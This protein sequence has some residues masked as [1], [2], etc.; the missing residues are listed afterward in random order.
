MM[1][2]GRGMKTRGTRMHPQLIVRGGKPA[3]VILGID[4]YRQMLERLE[5]VED[6]AALEAMK[7]KPLRFR[8]FEEF[9]KDSVRR[10]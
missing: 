3:A 7:K 6:L 1:D 4:E 2:G 9:L 5:D 10:V 8:K